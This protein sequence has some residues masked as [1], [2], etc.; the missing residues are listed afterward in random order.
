MANKGTM[1]NILALF[2]SWSSI[3]Q[4]VHSTDNINADL[5]VL[6]PGK[7]SRILFLWFSVVEHMLQVHKL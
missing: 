4:C 1:R 6:C 5:S 7:L 2:H 3:M